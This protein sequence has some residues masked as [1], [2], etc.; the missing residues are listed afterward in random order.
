M[1]GRVIDGKELQ[2]A[3]DQNGL[4]LPAGITPEQLN[5]VLDR[6]SDW[7]AKLYLQPSMSK[8]EAWRNEQLD[9]RFELNPPENFTPNKTHLKALDYRNGELD[10]YTFL[11][12]SYVDGDNKWTQVVPINTH[13]TYPTRVTVGGTSPRWW[14]FEDAATDFGKLDIAKPDLAKLLL[15][16]FVLIY[17]DDWFSIPLPVSMPNLVRIDDLIV[18]NVFGEDMKI[19]P[20]RKKVRDKIIE[21]GGNPDDPL[22]RWEIFTLAPS[23]DPESPAL[24][25]ILLVPPVAGFREESPPIEEVRFLRDEGANMV[26]GVEHLIPNGL[27]KPIDGFDAQRE[28]AE[29]HIEAEIVRLESGNLTSEEREAV[30][31][32]P[33]W[34][35]KQIELLRHGPRPSSSAVPRY[36]LSTIVPENWIPFVPT[37]ISPTLGLTYKSIRLRR[38]QMLRNTEAEDAEPI[39]AMSRILDLS[40]DPLLWLEEAT[41]PRSGLRA[42]LTAQRVRWVDGKTYVWLG[43]KVTT[44]RGEGSSGLRFDVLKND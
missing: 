32:D 34:L 43:R 16:E 20:V 7:R 44:G 31:A 27:G 28:R 29:R 42:Q 17:G 3:I 22:L 1:A 30:E 10:W 23:Y 9:Y 18:Y 19:D 14:A 39:P 4:E 41:V 35:W 8:S 13:P 38:A 26:W 5:Q 15:M 25:D 12:E 21:T 6:F 24:A 2:R 36:R 11:M 33:E 37:N 40:E